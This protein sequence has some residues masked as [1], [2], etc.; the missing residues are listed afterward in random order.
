MQL[1]HRVVEAPKSPNNLAHYGAVVRS[2]KI[3][4]SK[5]VLNWVIYTLRQRRS[6]KDKPHA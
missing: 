1:E 5:I 6:K 3:E 4:G 2:M